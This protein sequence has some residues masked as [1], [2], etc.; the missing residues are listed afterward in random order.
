MPKIASHFKNCPSI[1]VLGK[2]LG[3]AIAMEGGLK[4]KETT[5]VHAEGFSS[6]AFKH[7]PLALI[8]KDSDTATKGF[9]YFMKFE[10][11]KLF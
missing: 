7:G 4:I 10:F 11:L 6:G 2:G 5:Y 9:F 1:Y 8:S 3:T